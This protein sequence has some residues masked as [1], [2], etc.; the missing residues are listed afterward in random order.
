LKWRYLRREKFIPKVEYFKKCGLMAVS[1]LVKDHF[2]CLTCE[3]SVAVMEEYNM[4]IHYST[5][6]SQYES[7]QGQLINNKIENLK[8]VPTGRSFSVCNI[9]ASSDSFMHAIYSSTC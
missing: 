2:V 5:E 1:V 3:E 9:I 7:F 4:K 6:H 8:K